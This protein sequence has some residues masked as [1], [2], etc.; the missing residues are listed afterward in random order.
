[1]I[2]YCW[3]Y[4]DIN[5]PLHTGQYLLADSA[6]ELSE[7]VIPAYKAPAAYQPKNA[8][9]NHCIAKARVRNEHA[10]GIL[11][12]RFASLREMR[13][14]LYRKSDMVQYV[15][16]IYCCIILH[17]MLANLGD[18]WEDLIQDSDGMDNDEEQLDDLETTA[19]EPRHLFRQG[20]QSRCLKVNHDRGILPIRHH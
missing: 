14:H 2:S 19:N 20:V 17:N 16:W 1:M 10:I 5:H 8:N 7:T 13:L 9:F 4:A 12:S 11:K 18:S 6:Y 3:V 15:K